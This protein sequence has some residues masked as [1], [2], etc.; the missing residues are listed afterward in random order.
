M[1][2]RARTIVTADPELDDLNS[3]LRLLLYTNEF[4]LQGLVYASSRFHWRGDGAGTTFFLP[5]REYDRPQTS[6]RWAPGERFMHDAVE[7]YAQAHPLLSVHDERYPDPDALRG[8]IRYGNVDFEGDMSAD[9]PGSQLI[10]D[11]LLDDDPRP[12]HLQLW[13]GPAT[14]ARALRA[15]EARYADTAEWEAVHAAVSAKAVITKF[16]SQDATYDEYIRPHWP[17]I[18]V[19]EAATFAWGYFARKTLPAEDQRLLSAEWM[20]EN[21][22]GVGPLG[23]LYRVWGDGRQMVPGDPTDFFHLSGRTAEE[24]RAEG[25]QVWTD[26]QPAGEWISEGDTTTMLNLL[27]PGLR[28]FEHPSFGGWGGRAVRTDEGPDTW[29][30]VDTAFG[31]RGDEHSVTRWFAD[32]QADFAARLRWSITPTFAGANH[33]PQL[34]VVGGIDREA[35]PG[36]VVLLQAE[37][38]DPDG[39]AVHVRWWLDLDASSCAGAQLTPATGPL[40]EV[41]L[42]DD[43]EPGQ[44]V[45]LVAE[46]R[47]D[48]PTHPLAAW[49][50]VIVTVR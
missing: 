3:L 10:A 32:A 12:L 24:L 6:W 29:I 36:E 5:G 47:D 17:G 37:A 41:R 14:V 43:A 42:P 7:A 11:A 23:A 48:H 44:T 39:D 2:T 4:D 9:T 31:D 28:G 38:S 13:A 50:R 26:P 8:L 20:S 16:A 34:R 21:V 35:A 1:T 49:Q 15:I 22:T 27:V 19:T 46:A 45:H 40:A 25:Y 33:H 18:R 30:T